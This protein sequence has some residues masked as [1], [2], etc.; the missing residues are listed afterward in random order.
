MNNEGDSIEAGRPL[1]IPIMGERQR[2][3]Q[4]FRLDVHNVRMRD[5]DSVDPISA[6]DD[7]QLIERVGQALD[8]ARNADA[9][10]VV[11]LD[12]FLCGVLLQPRPIPVA[13]WLPWVLDPARGPEGRAPAVGCAVEALAVE[14][15]RRLDRAIE[16]RDWFDPWVFEL[17]GGHTPSEVVAPWVAGFGLAVDVFPGLM[18]LDESRLLEPL[19]LLYRHLD[20]DDLE[21]ADSLLEQIESLEPPADVPE[22]VEELVRST[23]LLADIS[24]PRSDAPHGTSPQRP[25]R[26]RPAASRRPTNRHR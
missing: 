20:P 18:A 14:R 1:P 23:L 3:I 6:L 13:Q 12:G 5:R 21:D 19:A 10:D 17:E 2:R 25:N 15:L 24:R 9:L 26:P 22:A 4:V 16:R 11:A 7:T 8:G